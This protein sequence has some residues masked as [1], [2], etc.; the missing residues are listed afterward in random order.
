MSRPA[1]DLRAPRAG[2]VEAVVAALRPAD[3]AE[4]AALVGAERAAGAIAASLERSALAWTAEA[5]GQVLA[6]LGVTPLNMLAG[7][8]APW[9]M[10]TAGVER[11]RGALIRLAPSY[12]AR[13]LAAFPH[14]RNVVDAR[15]TRSIAWLRRIGFRIGAPVP[16]G[17]AGLPFHPFAMDA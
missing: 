15:N 7:V 10:A 16:V 6:V 2:D 3:A 4:C 13:M 1:V 5:D 17:V 12:I 9:L 8:G 11:H 14:L